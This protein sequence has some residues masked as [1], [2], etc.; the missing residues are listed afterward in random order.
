MQLWLSLSVIGRPIR[1]GIELDFMLVW[2]KH[3]VHCL[4]W[5]WLSNSVTVLIPVFQIQL[6]LSYV[7]IDTFVMLKSAEVYE[8]AVKYFVMRA[9][10]AT[11]P[12]SFC[13]VLS[14]MT[15]VLF[16]TAVLTI[17][18]QGFVFEAGAAADLTRE[19]SQVG[20]R[21]WMR[22][23]DFWYFGM[24]DIGDQ[25]QWLFVMDRLCLYLL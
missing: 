12:F 6:V 11:R 20:I 2:A 22:F 8:N 21:L 7:M 15:Y 9:M 16:L 17:V 14:L 23:L 18:L 3:R 4:S 13:L 24:I 19:S 5:C 1:W 25:L 10:C